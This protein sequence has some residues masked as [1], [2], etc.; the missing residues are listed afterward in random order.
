MYPG[1]IT[2]IAQWR[3][4]KYNAIEFSEKSICRQFEKVSKRKNKI[5]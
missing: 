4:I 1:P 3:N 5:V 2:S